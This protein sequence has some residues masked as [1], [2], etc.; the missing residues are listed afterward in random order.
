MQTLDVLTVCTVSAEMQ[1][2]A[3][4]HN[5]YFWSR[6]HGGEQSSF[7]KLYKTSLGARKPSPKMEHAA[8]LLNFLE[9]PFCRT[10]V[11]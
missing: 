6:C 11:L 8:K 5:M 10:L 2:L 1:I 4:S 3:F 9:R 7:L